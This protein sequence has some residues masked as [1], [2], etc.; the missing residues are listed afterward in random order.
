MLE[1]R[2]KSDAQERRIARLRGE[3]QHGG[4]G[5]GSFYR[6]DMHNDEFLTE[7]KR[8]DNERWI[9]LDV[10]ELDA[11]RKRAARQGRIPKFEVEIGGR[12]FVVLFDADFQ[13]LVGG[14]NR[15]DAP[16]REGGGFS[17]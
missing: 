1:R 13:E 5:S 17:G 14:T 3:K 7:C 8:T 15:G 10:K 2:R 4:S 9:R 6:N 12:D 16:T 11:L